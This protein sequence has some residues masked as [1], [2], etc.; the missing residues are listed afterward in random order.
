MK[1]YVILASWSQQGIEKIKDSPARLDKVKE[2]YA[3]MGA[4]VKEFYLTMGK[5]DMVL[6]VEAPDD[7]VLAKLG[8]VIGSSGA[9]RTQ[10]LRAFP[11]MEYRKL[12]AALP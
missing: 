3:R 9:V 1:T 7:D 2:L 10:S 6:I 11:E 12:I 5:Y 4:T 8:L